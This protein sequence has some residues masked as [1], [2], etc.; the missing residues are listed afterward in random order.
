MRQACAPAY[1][2]KSG[3]IINIGF[4]AGARPSGLDIPY[5]ASKAGVH[6]LTV[7]LARIAAP[8]NINVNAVTPGA[9][10][11][12]M[13]EGVTPAL[14]KAMGVKPEEVYGT[15]CKTKHLFRREVMPQDKP[16]SGMVR[17]SCS[18]RQKG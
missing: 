3:K 7:T 10:R 13:V 12:P 14:A 8:Y 9:V 15:F 6:N 18:N 4:V 17:A 2:Q 1:E 5:A 11:T 16:S